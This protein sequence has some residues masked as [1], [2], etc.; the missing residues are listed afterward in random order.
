MLLD[1]VINFLYRHD[2]SAV[3]TDTP[4]QREVL[5]MS[6]TSPRILLR[7]VG[8]FPSAKDD[9]RLRA[10]MERLMSWMG[11]GMDV[12][13]VCMHKSWNAAIPQTVDF[14]IRYL[15]ER[16]FRGLVRPQPEPEEDLLQ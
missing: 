11:A 9:E 4:G 16:N 1:P 10:W 6:L 12:A 14:A 3:I 7:F 5:H 15:Y 8:C 13:Y 2:L